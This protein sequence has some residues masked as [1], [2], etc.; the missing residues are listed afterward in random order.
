MK[1]RF[2]PARFL[3]IALGAILCAFIA[4]VCFYFFYPDVGRLKKENPRKTSFME[5]REHEW[6]EQ[7]KKRKFSSNGYVFP[8]S[9]LIS[10]RPY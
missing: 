2:R 3:L 1:S 9:P 10:S 4:N 6:L 8:A 7:G 5:Y